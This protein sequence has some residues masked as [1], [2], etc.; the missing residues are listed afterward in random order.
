M[1]TKSQRR[2]SFV[3]I[4]VIA[5]AVAAVSVTAASCKSKK[6]SGDGSAS[7][8][9][10][11]TGLAA[12]PADADVIVS[13]DVKRLANAPLAQRG[14]ELLLSHDADLAQRWKKLA[15]G[16]QLRFTEQVSHLLL[17]LGPR[18]KAGAAPTQPSLLVAT[19]SF[20]EPKLV[21]CARAVFAKGGG[22]VTTSSAAGHTLYKI[23][24]GTHQIDLAFGQSDTVLLGTDEAWLTTALG[25]GPKVAGDDAWKQRLARPDQTAAVWAAG[26]VDDR[27][28][29]G[30]I[31][32]SQGAMKN[33]PEMMFAS[34]DAGA[35]GNSGVRATVG[36]VLASDDD[37]TQ[38]E[39]LAKAQ[40]PLLAI[41]AQLRGAGMLVSA[42]T[43]HRD[44]RVF[45][46]AVELTQEQVNQLLSTIDTHPSGT[47][48][49]G[50]IA[51]PPLGNP[52]DAGVPS[53]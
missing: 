14:V 16:C 37:A 30:L 24:D 32:V 22:T 40:L 49:A 26:H 42:A 25:T 11:V 47:E 52:I 41:A 28:G 50:P 39:S 31:R 1:N 8:G 19:G 35:A 21:A 13:I 3:A 38:L 9:N 23:K 4:A 17:A 51:T 2:H 7:A 53:K 15:D 18:P 34:F 6:K 12:I 33:G 36:A 10:S 29:Q 5:G 20:D 27:V 46:L 45:S 48:D 44:G 43:P